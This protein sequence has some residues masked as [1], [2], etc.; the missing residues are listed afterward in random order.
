MTIVLDCI[1]LLLLVDSL[2]RSVHF[3][4]HLHAYF[5]MHLDLIVTSSDIYCSCLLVFSWELFDND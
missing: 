1:S 3:R 4:G 5:C 2:Q